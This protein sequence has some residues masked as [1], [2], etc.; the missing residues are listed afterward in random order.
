MGVQLNQTINKTFKTIKTIKSNL[1][2]HHRYQNKQELCLSQ[3]N[4]SYN[5]IRYFVLL[6]LYHIRFVIQPYINNFL[7][8]YNSKNSCD[9]ENLDGLLK[10]VFFF[11]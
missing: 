10:K 3:L 9:K 11:I 6:V 2:N 1:G 4:G 5:C 7:N 8:S